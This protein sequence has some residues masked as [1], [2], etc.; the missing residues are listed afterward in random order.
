[1]NKIS[2]LIIL[3][4]VF[5]ACTVSLQPEEVVQKFF[6]AL[7]QKNFIEAEKYSTKESRQV[8]ETMANFTATAQSENA[9]EPFIVKN[10][11]VNGDY[12][13]A[14]VSPAERNTGVKLYLVREDGQWKV[15]FDLKSVL[16]MSKDG[17]KDLK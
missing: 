16:R 5:A 8:L 14:E 13:T 7:Q 9:D 3:V 10:V 11:Q 6:T 2:S 4:A 1:M 12:A 15:S 17:I